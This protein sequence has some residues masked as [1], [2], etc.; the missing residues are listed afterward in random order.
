MTETI[1]APKNLKQFIVP[2]DNPSQF[3]TAVDPNITY[4]LPLKP[5]EVQIRYRSRLLINFYDYRNRVSPITG[6]YYLYAAG[7]SWPGI[8]A[9][10][11]HYR[12]S[13]HWWFKVIE[14]SEIKI[15]LEP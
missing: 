10:Y 12:Q 6:S 3:F 14:S 1:G 11:P 9:W 13:I 2:K 15:D 4:L 7:Q 5:L 8:G